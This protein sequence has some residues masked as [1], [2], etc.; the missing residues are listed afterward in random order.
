MVSVLSVLCEPT[1]KEFTRRSHV[2][3]AAQPNLHFAPDR[4]RHLAPVIETR[5]LAGLQA[6]GA[7]GMAAF[8]CHFQSIFVK[9][10]TLAGS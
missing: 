10:R 9:A 5:N 7:F 6:N 8:G 1:K 3:P 2:L 4:L